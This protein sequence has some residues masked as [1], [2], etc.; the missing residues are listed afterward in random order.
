M[1]NFL[2]LGNSLWYQ[3]GLGMELFDSDLASEE[4]KYYRL[5]DIAK[6][7]LEEAKKFSEYCI[8][9]SFTAKDY[10]ERISK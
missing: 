4:L 10:Y 7:D 3:V 9:R 5:E 8:A 1:Q 2:A 6:N